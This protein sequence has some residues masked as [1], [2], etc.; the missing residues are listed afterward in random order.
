MTFNKVVTK[1]TSIVKVVV[2]S[3]FTS[4]PSLKNSFTC[5]TS[6]RL[7][8]DWSGP[9]RRSN[10][11]TNTLKTCLDT[12]YATTLPA[13]KRRTKQR[14][15]EQ[16]GAE[17]LAQGD[18]EGPLNL[19]GKQ[20][21]PRNWGGVD[22]NDPELDP[23][24]QPRALRVWNDA[25][26]WSH[27]G[28]TTIEVLGPSS[29]VPDSEGNESYSKVETNTQRKDEVCLK[30][31]YKKKLDQKLCKL[32]HKA[33]NRE[34]VEFPKERT[35][36][37]QGKTR[38]KPDSQN[39]IAGM[40]DKAL[41]KAHGKEPQRSM[42]Q[43]MEPAQQIASWIGASRARDSPK[44][45]Q[46]PQDPSLSGSSSDD[47]ESSDIHRAHQVPKDLLGGMPIAP[48][49]YD[50]SADSRAFHQFV[51]EGTAY[52]E[53]GQVKSWEQVFILSHYLKGRA[54]EFYI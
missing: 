35:A 18:E 25:Q 19:K 30:A 39:P 41:T 1:E 28:E 10:I 23:E 20:P 16:A 12:T 15:N 48:T 17:R 43:V 38:G 54:H 36:R 47:S 45:G 46:T 4:Q 6:C 3:F 34:M 31:Y 8:T 22:L 53:A 13:L 26:A 27:T 37:L 33:A 40:I 7:G 42:S 21:D 50:S 9:P 51:T 44:S 14:L 49:V 52:V 29:D 32:R 11:D 24:A 2:T 5:F